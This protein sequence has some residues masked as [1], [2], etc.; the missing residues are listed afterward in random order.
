M[1]FR[2]GIS[3]SREFATPPG[4]RRRAAASP[5]SLP[6]P[7]RQPGWKY[8]SPA[9][10]VR[11]LLITGFA[12][13]IYRRLCHVQSAL[14][15]LTKKS[16]HLVAERAPRDFQTRRWDVFYLLSPRDFNKQTVICKGWHRSPLSRGEGEVWDEKKKKSQHTQIQT[17]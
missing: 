9:C 1:A 12:L 15:T 5:C 3:D 14:W 2:W 10:A 11:C 6:L 16:W 7:A 8:R 13:C 4:K 17:K